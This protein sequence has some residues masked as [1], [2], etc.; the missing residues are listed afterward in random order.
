MLKPIRKSVQIV[1]ADRKRH[2]VC[3]VVLEP[4]TVDLQNDIISAEEIEQAAH[5]FLAEYRQIGDS[6]ERTADAT[7]VESYLAPMELNLNG[8]T[9]KPGSWVM[10]TKIHNVDLWDKIESGE[11][12]SYSIGGYA[13]SGPKPANAA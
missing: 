13:N 3:G 10:V 4:E 1:K 8:Q 6:H 11:Y 2:L 5:K 9:I 7:V 12:Q